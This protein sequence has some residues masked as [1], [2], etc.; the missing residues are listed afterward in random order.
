MARVLTAVVRA[1]TQ[2]VIDSRCG[3]RDAAGMTSNSVTSH[4]GRLAGAVVVVLGGTS[5]IGAATAAQAIAEGARVVIAGRRADAGAA[6]CERLGA[7]AS[8]A[9]CDARVEQQVAELMSSTREEFGRLD[10]LVNSAGDGG[11]RGGVAE[12]DQPGAEATLALHVGGTLAAMKHAAAIMLEQGS[13]SIVNVAS[14]G[15]SAAG[16]TGLAYAV[17][18]AAVIHAS[19]CAAVELGERGIRVNSVSPGPTLTGIFAKAAGVEPAAADEQ[20]RL[21]EPTFTRALRDWQALPRPALAEDVAPASVWLLSED[22][23]FVNGHDLIVDGGISAGRPA[24][25]SARERGLIAQAFAGL[26]RPA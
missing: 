17:A 6:L 22:A 2:Q 5:G 20:A 25:V 9:R 10:G 8:F 12:L 3:P 4:G 7:S 23:R 1:F 26:A 13:G 14:I 18:K 15:G 24:S 11:A 21:L 16:W 19:R